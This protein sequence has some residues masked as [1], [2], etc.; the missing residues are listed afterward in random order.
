MNEL[1]SEDG[2]DACYAQLVSSKAKSQT[3]VLTQLQMQFVAV[4][5][6]Y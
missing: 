5:S 4:Q 3:A 1:R 6:S 2:L